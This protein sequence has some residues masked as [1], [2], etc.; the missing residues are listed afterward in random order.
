M[1]SREKVQQLFDVMDCKRLFEERK[2]EH[3]EELKAQLRLAGLS[4]ADI[5]GEVKRHERMHEANG[6]AQDLLVN[7]FAEQLS[8]EEA[9]G[10]IAFYTSVLFDKLTLT[11]NGA[12][13]EIQML[14]EGEL[15]KVNEEAFMERM[16]VAI[17]P[18]EKGS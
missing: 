6:K 3:T 12:F 9:D 13:Q 14:L 10:L 7:I 15:A 8:E 1:A 2:C 16:L 17:P 11:M 5:V 4:E 18:G